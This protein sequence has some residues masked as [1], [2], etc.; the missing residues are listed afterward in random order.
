MRWREVMA[1]AKP[2]GGEGSVPPLTPTRARARATKM[3]KATANLKDVQAASAIRIASA[4]RKL[5]EI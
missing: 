3:A 2:V 4:E 5:S 1:E